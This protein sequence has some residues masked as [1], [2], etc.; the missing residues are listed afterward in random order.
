M[1]LRRSVLCSRIART[2]LYD[3]EISAIFDATIAVHLD[4]RR[5]HRIADVAAYRH[6]LVAFDSH[7]HIAMGQMPASY[8]VLGDAVLASLADEISRLRRDFAGAVRLKLIAV[9]G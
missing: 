9:V 7:H 2:Y 6:Q 4:G 1:E 5:L 3:G 8:V